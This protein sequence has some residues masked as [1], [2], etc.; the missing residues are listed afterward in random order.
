MHIQNIIDKVEPYLIVSHI[1]TDYTIGKPC[2]KFAHKIQMVKTTELKVT[3]KGFHTQD[4]K[5]ESQAR[6]RRFIHLLRGTV[7]DC[8]LANDSAFLVLQH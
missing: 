8:I 2:M 7:A 4:K 5:R 3:K 1:I 6:W